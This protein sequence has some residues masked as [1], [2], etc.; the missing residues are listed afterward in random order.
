MAWQ[1]SSKPDRKDEEDKNYL[2]LVLFGFFGLLMEA[3]GF[4]LL[5]SWFTT[6]S[7]NFSDPS[8]ILGAILSIVGFVVLTRWLSSVIKTLLR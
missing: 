7:G 2:Y 3:V 6:A 8:L 4:W 5:F 1:S